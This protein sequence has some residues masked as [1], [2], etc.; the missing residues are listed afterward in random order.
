MVISRRY[1]RICG[2][3]E[4]L[5]DSG[6]PGVDAPRA[7]REWQEHSRYLK[8]HLIS[9]IIERCERF[10]R[11][12]AVEVLAPAIGRVQEHANLERAHF[13]TTNYDRVIEH[14]CEEA[15][16]VFADGFG[17]TETEL[18]APWNRRFGEKICIYKLHGSVN[19]YVDQKQSGGPAFLRLDRGYP[20]PGPDF[21]LSREGKELEPL[22]VLPTLEKDALGDPY[23]YL[24]HLFAERLAGTLFL[25]AV[26]TSLR[27]DHLVSS[28]NYNSDKTV[29]LIVDLDP[30]AARARIPNVTSVQLRVDAA[31][32]FKRSL[33]RLLG[34]IEECNGDEPQDEV[35]K[36]MEEFAVAE[37][38]ELGR[39]VTLTEEQRCALRCV[40]SSEDES[41]VVRAVEVL[42]GVGDEEV[43]GAV[44]K[45]WSPEGSVDV[46]KAVAAC[47][48]WSGTELGV[49][50]LGRMAREE[51]SPEVRLEAYLALESVGTTEAGGAI[52]L[53]GQRWKGDAY[54]RGS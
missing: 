45:R 28:I 27:D 26:G 29:V 7:Y 19:Y 34:A 53:A 10:E 22:M 6:P 5:L 41:E 49:S 35:R 47:L 9:Y 36:L 51:E 25:V 54:F 13:F 8:A 1:C 40:V 50:T 4:R 17:S 33:G 11:G 46:R 23:G 39:G 20:L 38:R 14:V 16:I 43:V 15:G 21:R 2:G 37:V 18:V 30:D 48:G 3:P 32:F 44:A 52:E 24:N 12:L 31:E 42:R